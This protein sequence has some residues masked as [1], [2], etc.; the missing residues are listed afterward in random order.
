MAHI[1]YTGD[2]DLV[3][4]RDGR[5]RVGH[6]DPAL[7]VQAEHVGGRQRGQGLGQVESL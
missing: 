1:A 2:R 4:G 6:P 5:E 7:A 3:G